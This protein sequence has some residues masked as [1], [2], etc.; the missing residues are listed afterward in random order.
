MTTLHRDPILDGPVDLIPAETELIEAAMRWHF[1]PRTGSRFWL[2]Q[3]DTLGFD[4]REDIHTA[5]DLARFPNI[6]DRLRHVPA[7]DL[8]PQGY[9]GQDAAIYG[10][11]DSGGTTGPPKHVVFMADWMERLLARTDQEMDARDYPRGADW[12]ALAPSGPHMFGAIVRETVRL[13][14]RL[15]FTV[16]LDP[17]WVKKCIAAGH[18]EQAD[19]Y[20]DHIIAQ[21][22]AILESQD[23]GVLV[24]TPPLLERLVRDDELRKL[25]ADRVQVVE[26]G[27]AHMDPDTRYLLRTEVLPR[28]RLIGRYGSTMVLA[29]AIERAGLTP[30]DPCIFDSFSPYVTFRVVDPETG[31]SVPYGSRGR[32]VMNHVSK[33][34]LLPNN[35]ERDEATRIEPPP[36]RVGDSVADVSPVAVFGDSPVI[37]G[38]Y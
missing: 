21:A 7:G 24:A 18:P 36:G 2:D 19:Q 25:I 3:A 14:G 6:V 20:A 22:R 13:R 26:W 33:S 12:L 38:V 27:G 4:P 5:A 32:V 1:D 34:V 23:I 16:D 10:V 17:R 30:D 8:I 29:S 35:L 9:A 28:T 11:Y 31:E 37:E 15:N